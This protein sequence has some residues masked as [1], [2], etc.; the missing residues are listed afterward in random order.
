L[1]GLS[2]CHYAAEQ[3]EKEN[4]KEFL[5]Q[6]KVD[7]MHAMHKLETMNTALLLTWQK[8]QQGYDSAYLN[9]FY[10]SIFLANEVKPEKGDVRYMLAQLDSAETA[11]LLDSVQL[12]VWQVDYEHKTKKKNPKFRDGYFNV[13]NL[14]K[15]LNQSY[16]KIQLDKIKISNDTLYTEIKDSYYLG[17]SIGSYGANAYIADAVINLTSI[18]NIRY[19]KIDFEDGSHISPGTWSKEEFE[20]Y[21]ETK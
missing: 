16:P 15:G 9:K 17:E 1:F 10:D 19:V 21:T 20:N 5:D 14:I 12:Y 3:L 2:S 8:W 6:L 7:S 11:M 4:Q 13:D 18:Q